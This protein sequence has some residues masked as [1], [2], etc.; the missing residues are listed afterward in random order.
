MSDTVDIDVSANCEGW[1][2][3]LPGAEA[4]GLRA[5]E[6]AFAAARA[7]GAGPD[8]GGLAAEASLLLADDAF[9]QTLNRD[10]RGQDKPTNVLSFAN[11]DAPEPPAAAGEP[12]LLGDM[13]IALETTASEAETAGKP[14]SDHFSHLVVHGMLHLLGYDHETDAQAERM[15]RLEVRILEGLGIADPYSE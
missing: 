14:V 9:V 11:L 4:L 8:G 12:L 7:D 10:Y 3:V 13:V 6:A 15:E 5:A 1:A 2:E